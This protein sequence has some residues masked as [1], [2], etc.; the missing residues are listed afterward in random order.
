MGERLRACASVQWAGMSQSACG[1]DATRVAMEF[2]G[3]M[4]I[5]R[6]P[7]ALSCA[8]GSVSGG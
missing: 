8:G 2:I 1:L 3:V 7:D 6:L 5:S 4:P